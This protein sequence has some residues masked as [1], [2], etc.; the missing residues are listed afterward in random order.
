VTEGHPSFC[1]AHLVNCWILV[2]EAGDGTQTFVCAVWGKH[3]GI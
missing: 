1:R 3:S 2:A